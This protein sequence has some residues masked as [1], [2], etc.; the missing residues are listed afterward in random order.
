[1]QVKFRSHFSGEKSASCGPGNT[2]TVSYSRFQILLRMLNQTAE[3]INFKFVVKT[4]GS[5]YPASLNAI[6]NFVWERQVRD[7]NV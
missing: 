2:V 4:G 1:M 5:T 6:R 3:R 7:A